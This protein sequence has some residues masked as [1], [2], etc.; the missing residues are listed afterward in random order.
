[1]NFKDKDTNKNDKPTI[2]DFSNPNFQA[3]DEEILDYWQTNQIFEKSI[4]KQADHKDFVLYDGPPFANGLPHYGHLLTGYMKDVWGRYF[5]MKG[6]RVPRRF[7]WDCHGL[8][9]EMQSEKELGIMGKNEI[10]KFGVAKFNQHCEKSVMKYV[11]EWKEYVARQGRW[12]DFDNSYK[13][14]D[15]NFMESVLWGFKELYKK[16]YVYESLRIVPYSYACETPLSHFETRLDNSYREVVDK[17]I[18]CKLELDEESVC[19]LELNNSNLEKIYILIW[20]TTPWTLPSNLAVGANRNIEYVLI[21]K[22]NE[23]YILAKNLLPKYKEVIGENILSNIMGE[24]LIGLRYIPVFPYFQ[25][26]KQA[27]QHNFSILQG[28]FVSDTDG[29]GL[30]HLAPGFGE[31]DFNLCTSYNIPII[32]PID[33]SGKFTE[34]ISDYVGKLVFETIDPIIIKLKQQNNWVKT[35]QYRHNYPHCWRT[36]T[37]LIYRAISSWY[38]KVTDFKDEM[39]K[40]NQNINWIPEYVKNNLFGKWLENARDWAIS[41]NRF[42]GTPIPIWK[43]DDPR[44]PRVE[45]Y[46]SIEELEKAFGVKVTNL[47]KEYLDQ[48]EKPNPDDPNGKSKMVRCADVFDCWF[49][50]GSM[51]FAQVHYPF[52]NKEWFENNFP[53]DLIIEYS[54]QTRGWFYTLMVLS[55]ALFNKHPFSNCIAHGV[56]LDSKGQKLSKRLNNYEDPLKIFTKFGS[57]AMRLTMLGSGVT[58]GHELKL[59]S[60]G[61]MVGEMIKKVIKPF[62]NA[63]N[64]LVLYQGIDK[65]MPKLSFDAENV[66]DKYT[67][68]KLKKCI[69]TVTANLDCFGTT[70]AVASLEEF[71]D[72]LT[73]WFIR[74]SRQRFWANEYTKDKQQAY[75][76]LYTCL[77]YVCHIGAPLMPFT[78]EKVYLA[79]SSI[80]KNDELISD[81]SDKKL[82]IHLSKWPTEIKIEISNKEKVNLEETMD[83]VIKICSNILFIRN[84]CNLK[85][86]QPLN[87]VTISLLNQ[88]LDLTEYLDIIKEEVNVKHIELNSNVE[89]LAERKIV[90]NFP[91][92]G[93]RVPKMMKTILSNYKNQIDI[94][95]QNS[96][97]SIGGIALLSNEYS[98]SY[99]PK[100]PENSISDKD[101]ILSL[102]TLI[103]EE[104]KVECIARDFV[105]FIQ[106]AR[107]NI[108]LEVTQE[109]SIELFASHE[110]EEAV[111]KFRDY[112]KSQCL[113]R[114]LEI[115]SSK[116]DL[117]YDQKILAISLSSEANVQQEVDISQASEINSIYKNSSTNSISYG[118]GAENDKNTYNNKDKDLHTIEGKIDNAEFTVTITH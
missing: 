32:C 103:T 51:P 49:E 82:S 47:H 61:E 109:I 100:N 81:D 116:L 92:I 87:G 44:Y 106:S 22:G 60:K 42:W 46:G 118:G 20:T 93:K 112:I 64:F 5:T 3:I 95:Y 70:D 75:N 114:S 91:E 108:N 74:R 104:L 11:S 79:L 2:Y 57:D 14:M 54:A 43:S 52:E 85:V 69:A 40:L 111:I 76:T 31:E 34:E 1:M 105:R 50:S 58:K 37:P 107:K 59:D 28:D 89:K 96:N 84:K 53:A 56:I 24:K 80:F 27:N 110:I 33:N 35:E 13:T 101:F 68:L 19:K 63:V 15:V 4:S 36:D 45:V 66:L 97:L 73:N 71:L 113:I 78:T 77:I 8:P 12:V 25:N 88:K 90:L 67:L 29:T 38:I 48:L 55:T 98:I 23:G 115:K 21:Q 7:G 9:A 10:Q 102:D 86:R 83:A 30:V 16:G 72:V 99:V 17:S 41:R 94:E 6:Y 117:Q 26:L 62:Y 39:V 18:T 65:L